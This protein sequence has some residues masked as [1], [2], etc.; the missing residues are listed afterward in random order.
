MEPH[1]P[2]PAC[3]ILIPVGQTDWQA[4]GRLAGGADL[5]LNE[6][7]RHEVAELADSLAGKGL[8][9]LYAS[10]NQTA[11]QT[12]S[13]LA[14][15]L[16]VKLKSFKGLDE[17]DL[18]LWEGL[19]VQQLKQRYPR[20]YKQWAERPNAVCPPQG[21]QLEAASR[22]LVE[23]VRRIGLKHRDQTVGIV[24]GRLAMSLVRCQ[25]DGLG[26]EQFWKQVD[27]CPTWY[28]V[29]PS[30]QLYERLSEKR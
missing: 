30:A 2:Q 14:E 7:G 29:E 5:P 11:Q 16:G 8:S 13:L 27:R 25:I 10:Q 1:R 12:A 6:A 4:Q 18:G 28:Q 3:L 26:L 19:T 22:R 23:A 9:L 15:R 24:L 21:E 17:V 20:V